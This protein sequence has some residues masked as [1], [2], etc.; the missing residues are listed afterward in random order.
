MFRERAP[1]E[2]ALSQRAQDTFFQ[3]G[4]T[5]RNGKKHMLRIDRTTLFEHIHTFISLAFVYSE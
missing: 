1:T 4:V 2:G 3:G 5:S